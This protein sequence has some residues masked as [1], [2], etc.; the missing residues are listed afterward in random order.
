[1]LR[2]VFAATI[3][4][5]VGLLVIILLLKEGLEESQYSAQ[6]RYSL[7]HLAKLSSSNSIKLT[8][9]ARQH[10]VTLEQSYKDDYFELVGQIQGDIAWLDGTKRSYVTRLKQYNVAASDLALLEKSNSLS[11][12]LINTE[13]KAFAM[14]ANLIGKSPNQLNDQ[15]T[16]NWIAAISLL[17]DA[18]YMTEVEKIQ[19]PVQAF[20]SSIKVK[21]AALVSENNSRVTTL[22]FT[23]TLVVLAIIVTLILCY[24][25]L[26]KKVIKTTQ[27]LIKE[28]NRISQGDLSRYIE[29]SGND[30]IA[31]LADSFNVMIDKLSN[32][33]KEINSQSE[34]AQISAN[35]LDEVSQQAKVLNDKQSHAIEIISSSV[36]ENSTAVK[37]V[38]QNCAEAAQS[39]TSANE[40]TQQGSS[41]VVQGIKSVESVAT[42]LTESLGDLNN[43]ENSVNEVTVILSVISNIAE[44]T[45]L[46]ALNAAIEAARAGEQ[47]RGFAVVADE[48]RTLASRTQS[49]TIEIQEK[50]TSL[51]SASSAVTERIRASDNQIKEAVINSEKV[52]DMLKE[53]SI[54]ANSISDANLTIASASEEQSQVTEDIAQRLNDVQDTSRQTQMQTEKISQ[55]SS[56]LADLANN[57]NTQI[58]RFKL[59]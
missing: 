27:R 48:V 40:K 4:L 49:S 44:Q 22:S 26:E 7:S 46:L 23:S 35:N 38:S 15:E 50:I 9:L 54:Q 2:A 43:L 3:S 59:N 45:N 51:Q 52:G 56:E 55:S 8:E 20:L 31:K 57:L 30:E 18:A 24:L 36:Y 37:E 17:T 53:I 58:N 13:E 5:A 47:G 12:D 29:H 21:S 32:L 42:T 25:Q 1:M 33:L 19:Q 16:N 41:V 6:Q 39:A 28:A 10:V 11:L 14:I 34:Q